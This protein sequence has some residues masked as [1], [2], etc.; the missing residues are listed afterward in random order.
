[1]VA[2]QQVVLNLLKLIQSFFGFLN[3]L[4]GNV[5]TSED[6]R[7]GANEVDLKNRKAYDKSRKDAKEIGSRKHTKL[8]SSGMHRKPDVGDD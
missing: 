5:K 8:R 4:M 1:M 3:G 6:K 7:S 2:L